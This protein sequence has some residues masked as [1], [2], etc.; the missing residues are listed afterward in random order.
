[1]RILKRF[2]IIYL[3]FN[4][5]TF[6]ISQSVGGMP[7]SGRSWAK[8]GSAGVAATARR[9]QR[10][11]TAG[12]RFANKLRLQ[13]PSGVQQCQNRRCQLATRPRN[14][15]CIHFQPSA[16]I[17]DIDAIPPYYHYLHSRIGGPISQKECDSAVALRVEVSAYHS[18]TCQSVAAGVIANHTLVGT[19]Y[20]QHSITVNPEGLV[21]THIESAYFCANGKA[22]LQYEA[23]L[24][25]FDQ[26]GPRPVTTDG[27]QIRSMRLGYS[28]HLTSAATPGIL[29][30]DQSK[31]FWI[32]WDRGA[33]SLGSGSTVHEKRILKWKIDKRMK[34]SFIGFATKWGQPA[35]FRYV[36]RYIKNDSNV[37]M[38][39]REFLEK[40]VDTQLDSITLSALSYSLVKARSDKVTSVLDRLRNAST[41]DEGE[42]GWP[43]QRENSDWLYEEGVEQR[44]QPVT[45]KSSIYLSIKQEYKSK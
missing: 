3:P 30:S 13:R 8:H 2:K 29:S 10:H 42:F 44:K 18:D 16:D 28:V 9:G 27:K 15:V 6:Q 1:M 34:I 41:N 43:H 4:R 7:G 24:G 33:I 17:A 11:V 39:A 40:H 22:S 45:S 20:R 19:I 38:K 5:F 32:S 31:T 23:S 37:V 25:L 21:K 35:E 26:A 36:H 14:N 12:V